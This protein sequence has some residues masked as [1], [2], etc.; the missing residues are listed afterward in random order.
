MNR[1]SAGSF[2]TFVIFRSNPVFFSLSHASPLPL[3]LCVRFFLRPLFALITRSFFEFF[4]IFR[5]YSGSLYLRQSAF[6]C[7]GL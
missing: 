7:G 2:V 1:K 5:G 3:R 6:I 4:A